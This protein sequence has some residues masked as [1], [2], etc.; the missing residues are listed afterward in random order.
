MSQQSGTH[1]QPTKDTWTRGQDENTAEEKEVE[2]AAR[3][4]AREYGWR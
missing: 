2:R 3:Q 1:G 4:L